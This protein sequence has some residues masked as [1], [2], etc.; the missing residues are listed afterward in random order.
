[1]MNSSDL[2]VVLGASGGLGSAV[3]RE[4][5]RQDKQVRAVSRSVMK[6]VNFGNQVEVVLGDITNPSQMS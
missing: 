1:M 4:L 5:V 6:D 2:H 3:V